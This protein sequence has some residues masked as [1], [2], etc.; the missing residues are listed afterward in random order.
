MSAMA[1][2]LSSIKKY[3]LSDL[4]IIS[5]LLT[6]FTALE[7]CRGANSFVLLTDELNGPTAQLKILSQWKYWFTAQ[8]TPIPEVLNIPR[9]FFISETYS[10]V[11]FYAVFPAWFAQAFHL[12]I[13]RLLSGSGM[14][15]FA[16]VFMASPPRMILIWGA[17]LF[18]IFTQSSLGHQT[19]FPLYPLIGWAFI[20]LWRARSFY[21]A[22][23]ILGVLA[24]SM[25]FMNFPIG[26]IYLFP[27]I[28]IIGLI[29]IVISL[30]RNK[31][32]WRDHVVF[33]MSYVLS[34]CLCIAIDFRLFHRM[35]FLSI[36]STRT[37]DKFLISQLLYPLFVEPFRT[38]RHA[39]INFFAGDIGEAFANQI[40]VIIPMY[41]SLGL[42]LF[43]SFIVKGK[44]WSRDWV[45]AVLSVVATV[46][47]FL[48]TNA[49]VGA[50]LLSPAIIFA[51]QWLGIIDPEKFVQSCLRIFS[52]LI[53]SIPCVMIILYSLWPRAFQRIPQFEDRIFL[54][55]L[56]KYT[57]L[58]ALIFVI[59][60][61]V[62]LC[63]RSSIFYAYGVNI[64]RFE[65]F[66]YSLNFLSFLLAAQLWILL[67][68]KAGYVATLFFYT[69]QT[70]IM[71][72]QNAFFVSNVSPYPV[73]NRDIANATLKLNLEG[74]R[75]YEDSQTY[76]LIATGQY[77]TFRQTFS[78]ELFSLLR[79]HLGP[80]I[81]AYY[82]LPVGIMP[83]VLSFN[84]FQT[85]GA[86]LP[87]LPLQISESFYS[88]V[89]PELMRFKKYKLNYDYPDSRH[90]YF[91]SFDLESKCN[92]EVG[93][94]SIPWR[95]WFRWNSQGCVI[96]EIAMNTA[97]LLDFSDSKPAFL[98]TPVPVIKLNGQSV[99]STVELSNDAYRIY[100]YRIK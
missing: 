6:L 36:P 86:Y 4:G 20:K 31:T 37:K 88:I 46:V 18:G 29:T 74:A 61:W 7:F 23:G 78:E 93:R 45:I 97:A 40:Y 90:A 14:L 51:Q 83:S 56:K 64:L 24:F 12:W 66:R 21:D 22:R 39:M 79:G 84:G 41:A 47:L 35:F 13:M 10:R 95:T 53:L 82:V 16:S 44:N 54:G 71:I 9:G 89:E 87:M 76:Q 92:P 81:T 57:C 99:S 69:L 91:L 3:L 94:A 1:S 96:H 38:I 80:D 75:P 33:S 62:A 70:F 43:F 72:I 25:P 55:T 77:P 27:V 5:I 15:L 2:A 60:L 65:Y 30:L 52:A 63:F 32:S 59:G 34:V 28:G 68:R 73:I 19:T 98:I 49:Y 11:L 100:A 67:C 42:V 48:G 26:P 50:P 58:L 17:F 8:D 85:L